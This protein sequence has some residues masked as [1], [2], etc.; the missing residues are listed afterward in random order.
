MLIHFA[1]C[2][3]VV[4]NKLSF[5]FH[6]HA[7]KLSVLLVVLALKMRTHTS[8]KGVGPL[9]GQSVE[10]NGDSDPK[11]FGYA[12]CISRSA[13]CRVMYLILNCQSPITP[14][15]TK[16]LAFYYLKAG[17]PLEAVTVTFISFFFSISLN[18]YTQLLPYCSPP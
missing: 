8:R 16:R 13:D 7:N 5:F 11:R 12:K 14:T 2:E 3:Q 17:C 4:I 18:S 6:M 15:L 9:I 10:A 1:S